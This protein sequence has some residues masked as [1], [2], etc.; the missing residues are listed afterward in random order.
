MSKRA[1]NVVYIDD[2]IEE[3]GHDVTRFFFLMYSPDTHMNFDLGLAKEQSQ[4]NP[5]FYVQ[6][7]HARICSIIVKGSRDNDQDT[8]YKEYK[9]VELLIHEKELSL[10]KELNKFPELIEE[11]SKIMKFTSCRTMPSDWLINSILSMTHVA[12]Y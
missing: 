10:M 8:R 3:I 5:V 1:G 11:I 12:C 9:H 2:L 4:K 6:Y 7:A